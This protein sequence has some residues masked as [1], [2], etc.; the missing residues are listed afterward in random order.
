MGF[1][2]AFDGFVSSAIAP[3]HGCDPNMY[4]VTLRA[5]LGVT[6]D[7]NLPIYEYRQ[8]VYKNDKCC[9]YLV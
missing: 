9:P 7:D 5:N 2:Q 8:A 3:G 4:S 6:D 1:V